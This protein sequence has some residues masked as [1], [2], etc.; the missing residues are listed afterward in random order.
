M[1]RA[2]R[3][4]RTRA[5]DRLPGAPFTLASYLIEGGGSR[6]YAH[7]KTFMYPHPDAW[8]A[9]LALL[10]RL[11]NAYL[12]GQI[13]AGAEAVQLFDSWVGCLVAGRLPAPTSCRTRARRCRV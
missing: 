9:L 1:R 3:A 10:A 12:R 4:R 2:R 5:A 7:T 11:I 8:H 13:A 6:H